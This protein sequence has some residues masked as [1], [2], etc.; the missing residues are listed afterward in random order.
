M[1]EAK[2]EAE[3]VSLHNLVVS[4]SMLH[5]HHIN[6]GINTVGALIM[7]QKQILIVRHT[8]LHYFLFVRSASRIQCSVVT[9]MDYVFCGP[10]ESRSGSVMIV[11]S[12]F[13]VQWKAT[14]N[15]LVLPYCIIPSYLHSC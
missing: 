6:N 4:M 7:R 15:A 3:A 10:V 11:I 12:V 1:K 9:G 13:N 2:N 5:V 14:S 8:W